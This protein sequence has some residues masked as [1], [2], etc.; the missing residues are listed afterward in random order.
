MQEFNVK[1]AD[2]FVKAFLSR[3]DF[4][5][6]GLAEYPALADAIAAS[7]QSIRDNGMR[8]AIEKIIN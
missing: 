7:L 8:A 4:L 3:A 2:K 1:I 5:G 6:A